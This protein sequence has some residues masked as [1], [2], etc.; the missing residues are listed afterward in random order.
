MATLEE[1]SGLPGGPG[2]DDLILKIKAAV[3]IKAHALLTGTPTAGETAWAEEA[4]TNPQ[5]KSEI[6]IFYVLAANA[7]VT[8]AQ[9]LNA[10]DSA[11]QTNV[12]SA[13]DQLVT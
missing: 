11:I 10:S 2:W 13:V 9:I 4:L 1:L 5:N 3:I 12:N 6:I 7:G 8:T